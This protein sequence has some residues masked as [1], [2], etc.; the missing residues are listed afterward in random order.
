M[1]VKYQVCR[2]NII[3]STFVYAIKHNN[4]II[5]ESFVFIFF[6]SHEILF[7]CLFAKSV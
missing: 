6:E 2:G 3:C 7:F 5:L 1:Y 4:E